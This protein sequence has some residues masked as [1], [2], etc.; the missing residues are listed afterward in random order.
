[1][2]CKSRISCASAL[3]STIIFTHFAQPAT[4]YFLNNIYADIYGGPGQKYGDYT[5]SLLQALN[6]TR[7]AGQPDPSGCDSYIFSG[8]QRVCAILIR[9]FSGTSASEG[10]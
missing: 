9:Y 7:L 4:H 3:Q 2:R 6:G 5:E 1:M 8:S 10:L